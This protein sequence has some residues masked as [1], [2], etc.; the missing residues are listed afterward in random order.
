MAL[1]LQMKMKICIQSRVQQLNYKFIVYL[2]LLIKTNNDKHCN[3]IRPIV[4]TPKCLHYYTYTY[5]YIFINTI[6]T[7]II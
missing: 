1:I 5:T 4:Q 7:I 3:M 2:H 6:D